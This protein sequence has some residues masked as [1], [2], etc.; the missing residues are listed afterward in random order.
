LV[1]E[2]VFNDT[3]PWDGGWVIPAGEGHEP[4]PVWCYPPLHAEDY[5][6]YRL[7]GGPPPTQI[8][9]TDDMN[10]LPVVKINGVY[11]IKQLQLYGTTPPPIGT[12]SDCWE[13][14]GTP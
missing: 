3:D 11:F 9:M 1:V 14:G 4:E 13:M 6:E 5:E 8:A 10:P 2:P 7:E 12:Y